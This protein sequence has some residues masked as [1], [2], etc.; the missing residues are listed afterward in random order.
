MGRTLSSRLIHV[1]EL[2]R[3]LRWYL[4]PHSAFALQVDVQF[5]APQNSGP[6]PQEPNLLQQP[7]LQGVLLEHVVSCWAR[8]AKESMKAT[9]RLKRVNGALII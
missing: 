5:P 2:F 6:N 1:R 4:R 8:T 9:A 3:G 7:I